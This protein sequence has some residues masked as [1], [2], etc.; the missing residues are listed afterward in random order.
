MNKQE[1]KQRTKERY[2]RVK[3]HLQ[4]HKAT[5]ITGATCLVVGAVSGAY[6]SR[7][8]VAKET[9]NSAEMRNALCWKPRQNVL[10]MVFEERSTP[11]KPVFD[12]LS[13]T[14]Y[15]S[16]SEMVRQTGRP[17]SSILSDPNVEVFDVAASQ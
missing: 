13:N 5:Y 16:I 11:S 1:L 15:G 9:M 4:V 6:L 17:R 2:I 7:D 12:K 10:Q 3:T 14:G 8:G